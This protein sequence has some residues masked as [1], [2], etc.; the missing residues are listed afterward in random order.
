MKK[1]ALFLPVFF[2]FFSCDVLLATLEGLDTGTSASQ[3][4]TQEQVAK[5]LKNALEVG[6]TNAVNVVSVTNGFYKNSEIMIPFPEEAIKVKEVCESVGLKNKVV[7]FEEKLNRA[8]E[9]A[10]KGATDVFIVAIKQMTISDAIAILQGGDDAATAYLKKTTST[11][12]Y[13]KFYTVVVEAT[14]KIM[15]AQY[16]TPL[17][18]KYNTVTMLTGG[19][20]VDTDLNAYVT[21]K[22]LDGLYLMVA[23]EELKI[24][25]DHIARVTDI[26]KE[27]FGSSLNPYNN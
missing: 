19:E 20:Q 12:L 10:A 24:R 16:W 5:G 22:A 8:A 21:N 26:L 13:N 11:T 3:G 14:E 9:E 17:V 15:L 7:K 1:L 2:I 18:E 6:I 25:K 23:K 4:L 27:V